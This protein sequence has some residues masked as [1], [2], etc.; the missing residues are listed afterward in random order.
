MGQELATTRG[1]HLAAANDYFEQLASVAAGLKG[2]G[3]GKAFMKFDGNDGDYSYG[4]DDEPLKI[5]EQ[6]AV[7]MRSAEWGWVIWVDGQV[8]HEEMVP[9]TSR[10]PLKHNLPDHGPY[11]E[12]DGPS[13]Q[14]TIDMRMVEEPNIEMQFQ[15][16]NNSKRRALAALMKD[17]ANQFRM[18]PGEVPIIEL[19]ERP[20]ETTTK[21]KGKGRKITKHAPVFKIVDWMLESELL[22]MSQGDPEDYPEDDRDDP[23]DRDPAPARGSARRGE[24]EERPARRSGRDEPA[25]RGRGRDE[26]DDAPRGRGR[27]RDEAPA[28]RSRGRDRDEPPADEP[29]ARSR[30][31]DRDADDG[32]DG[33]RERPA[34]RSRQRD[35]EEAEA[36]RGRGRDRDEPQDDAPLTRGRGRDRD[37]AP[38]DDEPPARTSRR[39][40]EPDP[41]DEPERPARAART[42][43]A[44][45]EPAPAARSERRGRF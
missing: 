13:E 35:P 16:N 44:E 33:A 36:P 26:E 19:D 23:R 28:A 8:V 6:M 40:R 11:G 1:N 5:G 37:E 43:D 17:F 32:D 31:R 15:G 3:D 9:M 34:S 30:G 4:A 42:R 41:E 21:G 10:Q 12:D 24:Q 29:P 25:A 14:Y 39:Q 7:N 45:P 38:A 27:D 18:H 22:A 2:G 20:F